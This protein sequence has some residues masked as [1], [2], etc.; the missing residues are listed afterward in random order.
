M[1]GGTLRI[2]S[3]NSAVSVSLTET[4]SGSVT[5]LYSDE[6]CTTTVAQPVT[7]A[8]N[9]PT[10]LYIVN[11]GAYTLSVKASGVEIAGGYGVT[12]Q[13]VIDHGEFLGLRYNPSREGLPDLSG[14]Y[15]PLAPVIT[16][17]QQ[18]R[19]TADKANLLTAAVPP[20]FGTIPTPGSTANLQTITVRPDRKFQ[21]FLG[22]GAALT[23][24]SVYCLN[25]YLSTA[26]RAAL[27]DDLFNP[28][29]G[30]LSTVRIAFGWHSYNS[31]PTQFSY[32][33]M[34]VASRSVT[35]ASGSNTVTDAG[36]I[37]ADAGKPFNCPGFSGSAFVGTVTAGTGYTIVTTS[38]GGVANNSTVS[39]SFTARIST[40]DTGLVNFGLGSDAT[41]VIP[42]LQQILAINPRVRVFASVWSPP[43]WMRING[44][45]AG[46]GGRSAGSPATTTDVQMAYVGSLAS[47]IVKAIQAY[48]AA[49]IPIYSICPQNEPFDTS[50]SLTYYTDA[51]YATLVSTVAQALDAA[52][53]ETRLM[54]HD[55]HWSFTH[56]MTPL[57]G[58]SVNA[59]ALLGS[60]TARYVKDIG[61][62]AYSEANDALGLTFRAPG[63]YGTSFGQELV[64]RYNPNIE[65]HITE[66]RVLSA[67]TWQSAMALLAAG[68]VVGGFRR[69]ASTFTMWN[70][71]LD[72][73]GSP[74][75]A[76]AG[77]EGVV[78][79]PNDSSGNVV[80]NSGYY[81]L[82]H[83]GQ[84]V[85]PGATRIGCTSPGVGGAVQDV[86]AVA[87][88]NPDGTIALFGYNN[89][90][91]A[92]AVQIVDGRTNTGFTVTLQPYEVSTFTWSGAAV[93]PAA[94]AASVTVPPNV[95]LDAYSVGFTTANAN[96]LSWS[97]TIGVGRNKA[98]IVSIANGA[99]G[100][101]ASNISGV[102]FK[103]VALT[104]LADPFG[105]TAPQREASV[106]YLLNPPQGPGSVIVTGIS[107][108]ISSIVAVA[109]SWFNV[110]QSTPFGT[111]ATASA[112]SATGQSLTTTDSVSGDVVLGLYSARNTGAITGL[113]ATQLP[114]VTQQGGATNVL[115]QVTTQPGSGSQTTSFTQGTADAS[116][117]VAVTIHAG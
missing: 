19:T 31:S 87:F 40:P 57:D 107:N 18:Y 9:T 46:V 32:D 97:H 89:S 98:L 73:N 83:V 23:D 93:N 80:R 99:Q 103:G 15:A 22:V 59:S 64:H 100:T 16:Q 78:T 53:L 25:N 70:L 11:G 74:N 4:A 24:A 76:S 20:A 47:Y 55:H 30:G 6:A 26:Q 77:R 109:S 37:T 69:W 116:A 17:A 52:G 81:V 58:S 29:K 75:Q 33:D 106:W 95:L 45:M 1:A 41:S 117:A 39:G 104:K 50:G 21:E 110:S 13:V 115:L 105:T 84:Y 111:P 14:T 114:L 94:V 5:Q 8:S 79:I 38:G 36:A 28:A 54:A 102:T 62:H 90:Q 49:G 27:L 63:N 112:Q 91:Q 108:A 67:Q 10:L 34:P 113:Q 72:Q 12:R 71:A 42:I 35:V 101:P 61:W 7:V 43:V 48:Q 92:R 51:D 86:Q 60:T 85:K 82:R 65:Q 3:N 68:C 66:I 96:S 88:Q 56:R 44:D 2:E